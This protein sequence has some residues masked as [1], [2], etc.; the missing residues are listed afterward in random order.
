LIFG[1]LLGNVVRHAPGL[2][3]ITLDWNDEAPV[4]HVLDNGSGFASR[5]ARERLPDDDWSESGRGLFIVNACA[6]AFSV[7][8]RPG[9]G[10]HASATLPVS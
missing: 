3:E 10:T 4:L 9:C 7:Q 1:E 6:A 5:R 2:V 8:A